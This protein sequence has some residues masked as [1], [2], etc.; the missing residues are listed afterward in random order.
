MPIWVAYLPKLLLQLGLLLIFLSYFGLPS[1][2]NYL[3]GKVLT[4]ESNE[5]TGGVAAP[6]VTLCARDSNSGPWKDE[7][8]LEA[9]LNRCSGVENVF[10][11]MKANVWQREDIVT[12][13]LKGYDNL[14][15]SLEEQELAIL[16]S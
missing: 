16:S 12:K 15:K 10:T 6:A 8:G 4:V 3:E 14:E 13:A 2:Q 11:C 7:G 5:E 1:L 9:A